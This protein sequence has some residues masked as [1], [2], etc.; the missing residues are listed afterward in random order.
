M[1]RTPLSASDKIGTYSKKKK[2]QINNEGENFCEFQLIQQVK[3]HFFF[4]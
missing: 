4:E 3:S 1:K 2:K